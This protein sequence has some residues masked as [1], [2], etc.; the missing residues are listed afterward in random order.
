[1]QR[2]RWFDEKT[3]M[4]VVKV[5]QARVPTLLPPEEPERFAFSFPT[6]MAT[7]DCSTSNG[8][9]LGLGVMHSSAIVAAS[10]ARLFGLV[11]RNGGSYR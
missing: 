11:V 9:F 1:M 4:A 3:H 2:F 10:T 7:S 6:V 5:S 8:S